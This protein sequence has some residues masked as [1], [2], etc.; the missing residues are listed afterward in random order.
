MTDRFH[1]RLWQNAVNLSR[2]SQKPHDSLHVVE[3]LHECSV[4]G[5]FQRVPKLKPG[6]LAECQRCG[7]QIV[8]RRKT[9]VIGAPAAF[10]VASAALYVALLISPLMTLNVYGRENTVAL[11]SGPIE[12]SYQGYNTMS[13]LVGLTTLAM[14]GVVI[15]LMAAVLYGASRPHMPD[16]AP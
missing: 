10:C 8:R 13:L 15:V 11:M 6:F 12:L 9:S 7:S 1:K 16:W 14:P 4:C 2:T 3:G 5:L